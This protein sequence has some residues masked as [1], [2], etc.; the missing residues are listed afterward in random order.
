MFNP[1][2]ILGVSKDAGDE[3]IKKAYR[4]LAKKYHPDL[5]RGNAQAE[6]KFKEVGEA[7]KIL[8]DKSAR[9]A[10]DEEARKAESEE[11]ADNRRESRKQKSAGAPRNDSF[12]IGNMA[13][14]MS[15]SFERFFGFDPETGEITR[16]EKL[17]TDARKKKNPLDATAM[18]E[19][20][21]GFKK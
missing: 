13:Q 17:N 15:Q 21:M 1:Y 3:D 10:H 12:D 4:R 20:F 7:Y 5:N 14:G 18:F 9:K 11:T 19:R 6:I 2:E 8:T 16:E